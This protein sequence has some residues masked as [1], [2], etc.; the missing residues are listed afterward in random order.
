MEKITVTGGKGGV[1]KSTIAVLLANKFISSSKKV[2]LCDLDVECPNDHLLLGQKIEKPKTLVYS[3]FPKLNKNKCQKCGLCVKT[4]YN[5]TIFQTPG[6]YPIFLRNLCSSCGACW[7]VCPYEAV[8]KEKEKIGEIFLNKISD[9]FWLV[10]GLTKPGVDKTGLVVTDFVV[11]EAKKFANDF[12]KKMNCD[13]IL[14]D[15]MPGT[16]CPVI[17]GILDS[18]L[19][20]AVTEPTPMGVHDLGLILDL[21]QKLKVPAKVVLNQ[22]DLGD[23]KETQKIAQKFKT[24]IEMEIPYSKEIVKAYSEGQLER[25]NIL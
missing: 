19:V 7:V 15:T 8:E 3:Y 10:T 20:Y 18:D 17:S 24:N 5:H 1:G 22:A 11:G 2:I 12:A 16:H 9:N 14:F 21:C 13:L 4:C 6:E 25:V 23:K